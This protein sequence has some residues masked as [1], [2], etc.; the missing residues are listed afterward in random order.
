MYLE[1]H[2]NS[3]QSSISELPAHNAVKLS[4]S[5][6]DFANIQWEEKFKEFEFDGKL[7]DVS[8]IERSKD[9]FEIYCVN[10]REEESIVALFKEWKKSN[11]PVSKTKVQLQPL[12]FSSSSISVEGF[13]T[14]KQI[15]FFESTNDYNSEQLQIPSP[16]PR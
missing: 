7:F 11:L 4:F 2:R 16:P 3:F 14:A 9:G 5:K 15:A 13:G 6:K 12:F 1:V 8:K 10:D